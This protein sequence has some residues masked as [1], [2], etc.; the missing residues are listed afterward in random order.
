MRAGFTGTREGMTKSQYYAVW[1]LLET[2]GV[3]ELHHGDCVG[4]DAEA[5]LLALARKIYIVIHAPVD[6]THRAFCAGA[7]EVREAKT[8]FARNRD[9]VD[10]TQ[11]LIATP[12]LDVPQDH[13]GTWYTIGYGSKK[14]RQPYVVWPTG[15]VEQGIWMPKR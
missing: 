5:H 9:I 14:G 1:Y 7:S 12:L 8:H 11:I 13:G 6:E 10:E 15:R 2:L 4:A 3:T